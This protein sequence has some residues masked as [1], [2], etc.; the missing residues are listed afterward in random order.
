MSTIGLLCTCTTCLLLSDTLLHTGKAETT[1][2]DETGCNIVLMEQ[3]PTE[4]NNEQGTTSQNPQEEDL[5]VGDNIGITETMQ[6]TLFKL[7]AIALRVGLQKTYCCF[8]N[9][10]EF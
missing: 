8:N 7:L 1:S 6:S 3:N 10:C 4:D 9:Q 5:G 2:S